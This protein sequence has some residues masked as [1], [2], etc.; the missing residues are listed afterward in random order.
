[1]EQQVGDQLQKLT[2]LPLAI[3]FMA[4]TLSS[5]PT[6]IQATVCSAR[7]YISA[8][9]PLHI[10]MQFGCQ[11]CDSAI[12]S[13]IQHGADVNAAYSHNQPEAQL[14]RQRKDLSSNALAS[15]TFLF[16]LC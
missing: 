11:C 14:T 6:P 13:L 5:G 2:L 4:T 12:K 3:T 8:V 16:L 10:A 7:S 15:R 1:L 9:S